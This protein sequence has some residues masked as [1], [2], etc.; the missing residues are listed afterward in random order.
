M[1]QHSHPLQFG[2][3]DGN[4]YFYINSYLPWCNV[5]HGKLRIFEKMLQVELCEMV[6]FWMKQKRFEWDQEFLE[7]KQEQPVTSLFGIDYPQANSLLLIC[8]SSSPAQPQIAMNGEEEDLLYKRVDPES[9]HYILDLYGFY[10]SARRGLKPKMVT[11]VLRA[12]F[13][14]AQT[15][16]LLWNQFSQ[17]RIKA[18][19][20]HNPSQLPPQAIQVERHSCPLRYM[21]H[22]FHPSV[23]F[24]QDPEVED[25]H[26]FVYVGWKQY[27][28]YCNSTLLKDVPRPTP[29]TQ[30]IPKSKKQ[31][32]FKLEGKKREDKQLKVYFGVASTWSRLSLLNPKHPDYIMHHRI[33][34]YKPN[35]LHL[36]Y[37]S[38]PQ[39]YLEKLILY[40]PNPLSYKSKNSCMRGKTHSESAINKWTQTLK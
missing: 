39:Q 14:H 15:E 30:T 4:R 12:P 28:Q 34:I 17:K 29:P 27:E 16:L 6:Q 20:L 2:T 3:T 33:S 35:P 25:E 13:Q 9:D 26:L 19:H 1:N 22:K 21:Q 8:G 36:T 24:L 23:P 31:V 7:G 5:S 11:S 40:T 38:I 10:L 18:P 37:P 32:R